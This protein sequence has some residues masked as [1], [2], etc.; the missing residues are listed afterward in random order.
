[1]TQKSTAIGVILGIT[2]LVVLIPVLMQMRTDGRKLRDVWGHFVFVA[3]LLCVAAAYA[4]FADARQ[5]YLA[6]FGL[7]AALLGLFVQHRDKDSDNVAE[8]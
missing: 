7:V 4:F 6:I 1:V 3:G 8:K 5:T 2:A